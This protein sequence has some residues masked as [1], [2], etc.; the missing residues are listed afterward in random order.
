MVPGKFRVSEIFVTISKSRRRFE[1]V[2]KSRQSCVSLRLGFSIFD[3]EF[4][5]SR[6][7]V[8]WPTVSIKTM[9][10]QSSEYVGATIYFGK[11]SA[12]FIYVKVQ[13]P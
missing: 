8:F 2:S 11:S 10:Q 7:F 5:E 9:I 4:S 1:W 13:S 3:R 12:P 6:I